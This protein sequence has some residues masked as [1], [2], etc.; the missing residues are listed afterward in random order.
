MAS[1]RPL[2]TAPRASVRAIR[3]KSGAIDFLTWSAARNLPT[4][5][6]RGTIRRPATW[7]HRF[8]AS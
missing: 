1:S 6:S 3:T 5:S 8:G 2:P 7:P 4:A